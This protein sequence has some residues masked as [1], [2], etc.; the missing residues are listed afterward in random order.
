MFASVAIRNRAL[1]AEQLVVG[2]PTHESVLLIS[3]YVG[4]ERDPEE[5][6][7]DVLYDECIEGLLF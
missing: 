5:D 7:T 1:H 2:T 4:R 6:A 3:S